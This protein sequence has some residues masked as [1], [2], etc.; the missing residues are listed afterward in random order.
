M[1]TAEPGT[2]ARARRTDIQGLRAVAATLIVAFHAGALV[3]GGFFAVDIFF[4]ISGFVITAMLLREHAATGSISLRR[5]YLRRARRLL[6]SLAL[7]V[8]V[9]M[10]AG[11]LLLSPF[12]W[13]LLAPSG[14]TSLFAVSNVYFA[15]ATDG[16]FQTA[17][18]A[19]P[20]L[21][22]WSLSV[23]EQFYLV[24]PTVVLLA[25]ARG[26]RRRV[27]VCTIAVVTVVSFALCVVLTL[28]PLPGSLSSQAPRLAFYSPMTR[29]WEFGAGS[30]AALALTSRRAWP[31]RWAGAVAWAGILTLAVAFVVVDETSFPGWSA[32][33]PV[34]ATVL[35]IVSGSL[36]PPAGTLVGRA[37]SARPVTWLGDR[38]YTWY[39]WHWPMIVVAHQWWPASRAAEV[40]AGVASL[41]VAAV[42]YRWFEH[43]IHEGTFVRP[44]RTRPLVLAVVGGAVACCA[45]AGAASA[46]SFG[47]DHLREQRRAVSQQHL[48]QVRGCDGG[49]V[50]GQGVPDQCRW[51]VEGSRGRLLLVGDSHAGHY[52]E[53]FVDASA[54]L[55]YSADVVTFPSCPFALG[56]SADAACTSFVRDNVAA[57]AGADDPYDLVVVSTAAI[58]SVRD[59]DLTSDAPATAGR[60]R[61]EIES[62]LKPI[63]ARTRVVTVVDNVQF[64]QL[65]T[66]LRR[67]VLSSAPAAGC[68]EPGE[69]D[70]SLH[71]ASAAAQQAAMDA[72]GGDTLDATLAL[73]GGGPACR[74]VDDDGIPIFRDV[75][76]ITVGESHRLST[77]WSKRLAEVLA[78][79][80]TTG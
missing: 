24:F 76:H 23:E 75:S 32:A 7:V 14:L 66:C 26:R 55:G 72:V 12:S 4:V 31:S 59:P 3:P 27:L 40:L 33:L 20:L 80:R 79:P 21:H 57:L 67:S 35:L 63:A 17:S 58:N 69:I 73:C 38:S 65:M 44:G 5:F 53:A 8:G 42:V 43:P 41:G 2:S 46:T 10:V 45:V 49:L 9:T 34:A 56:E 77:V 19:V 74:P 52:T 60:W 16:Y 64:P 25:L 68:L 1:T 47:D 48:D 28:A 71:D 22:T 62:T 39:L 13:G 15:V 6:P 11:T 61:R 36:A 30:L 51:D 18:D 50:A 37:L 70:G 29:A 54:D 78:Q